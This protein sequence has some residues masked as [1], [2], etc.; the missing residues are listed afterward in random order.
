VIISP[1]LLKLDRSSKWPSERGANPQER[2]L[3]RY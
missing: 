3:A 2:R 1:P